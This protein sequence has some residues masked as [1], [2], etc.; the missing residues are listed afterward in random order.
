M[1]RMFTLVFA[2]LIPLVGVRA[3]APRADVISPDDE[4]NAKLPITRVDLRIAQRAKQILN[5]PEKWNR[6]DKRVCSIK[7]CNNGCP[8]SANTFSIYCALQRATKE[9]PGGFE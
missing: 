8:T 3:Q 4:Y 9:L 7:A 2:L 6:A 1:T 5:R